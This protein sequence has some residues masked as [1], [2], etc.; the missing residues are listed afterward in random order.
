M[1]AQKGHNSEAVAG[2]ELKNYLTK[3]EK[4]VEERKSI[5][6]DISILKKEAK[7]LGIDM[8]TFNAMLKLRSMDIEKRREQEELRELYID[9]LGLC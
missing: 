4:L 5:S 3:I 1:V 2:K 6:E 8:P 9:C 7:N